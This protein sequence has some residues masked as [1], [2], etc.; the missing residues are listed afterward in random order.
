MKPK[1][2]KK[3][4]YT[5]L[6]MR[7]DSKVR[8]YRVKNTTLRNLIIFV[9]LFFFIGVAGWLTSAR[10]ISRFYEMQGG[11][12]AQAQEL[13][14]AKMQLEQLTNV[15]TLVENTP[16]T[17]TAASNK[18]VGAETNF[19]PNGV[20]QTNST[21][22]NNNANATRNAVSTGAFNATMPAQNNATKVP[23]ANATLP[24]TNAAITA[25]QNSPFAITDFSAKQINAQ[26]L[27]IR[28]DLTNKDGRQLSGTTQ[29]TITYNNN[30][31]EDITPAAAQDDDFSIS[32]MKRMN[33]VITLGKGKRVSNIKEI[34]LAIRT[35]DGVTFFSTYP[36]PTTP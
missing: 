25:P 12:Q 28:Y 3:N 30:T 22:T 18:E 23:A 31:T 8:S 29:F 21:V 10:Y 26:K 5:L 4:Y 24:A 6:L 20:P 2:D 11:Y 32:R 34:G 7:D 1:F 35:E 36:Y 33:T 27:R 13:V 16:E 15:K 14:Q 17:K 9:V 19:T